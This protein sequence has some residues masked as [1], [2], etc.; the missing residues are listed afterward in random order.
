MRMLDAAKK[1]LVVQARSFAENKQF[2]E[3]SCH[4][5]QPPSSVVDDPPVADHVE[6][7]WRN[8][9]G[10][11]QLLNT[12]TPALTQFEAFYYW[13]GARLVKRLQ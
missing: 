11:R 6:S 3:K 12:D 1:S 2:R 13:D 10:N 8:I 4:L 5:F 7:F 9:Y